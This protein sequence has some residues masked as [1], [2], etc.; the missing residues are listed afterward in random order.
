MLTLPRRSRQASRSLG[1]CDDALGE[2]ESAPEIT[3][4]GQEDIQTDQE[5]RL[6]LSVAPRVGQPQRIL[7][8]SP[9]FVAVASRKHHRSGQERLQRQMGRATFV[10]V[11]NAA[12]PSSH[13]RRH[14]TNKERS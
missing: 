5:V 8:G 1:V 13:Q 14:S 3:D 6:I 2:R 10:A 11:G 4:A 12:R 9:R 7:D